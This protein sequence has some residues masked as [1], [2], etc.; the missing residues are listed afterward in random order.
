M[1]Q[2]T[3]YKLVFTQKLSN[4]NIGDACGNKSQNETTQGAA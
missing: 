3:I 1:L 4:Q 2:I